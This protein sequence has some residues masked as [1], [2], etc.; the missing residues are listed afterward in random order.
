MISRIHGNAVLDL[1]AAGAKSKDIGAQ[2]GIR[3]AYARVLIQRARKRGDP[4]AAARHVDAQITIALSNATAAGQK[5]ALESDRRG[6]S[7]RALV[8][9]IVNTVCEDGLFAAVLDA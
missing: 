3:A 1:W 7:V 9:Q 8:S 6:I 2:L 4:R 5:L